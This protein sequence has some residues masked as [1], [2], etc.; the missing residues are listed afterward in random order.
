MEAAHDYL[1]DGKNPNGMTDKQLKDQLRTPDGNKYSQWV[2][3]IGDL[4]SVRNRIASDRNM[5][6]Q[7]KLDMLSE[8]DAPTAEAVKGLMEY[9]TNPVSLGKM[10]SPMTRLAQQISNGGYN[11]GYYHTAQKYRDPNTREGQV[12]DRTATLPVAIETV[13]DGL[14]EHSETQKIP[15]KVVEQFKNEYYEGDP[16]YSKVYSGIRMFAT[17]AIGIASGGKPPVTSVNDLIRHMYSTS[18]PAQIRSQMQTD[19]KTALAYIQNLNDRWRADTNNPDPNALAP[20][21]TR[22]SMN[23]LDAIM[24]MNPYTGQMPDDAPSSLRAVG[25]PKPTGKD[26]P[27]WMKEGQDYTPM[28]REDVDYWKGWLK[29]NSNDPR[30]QAIRE[31][32]RGIP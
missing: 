5:T 3:A 6:P 8:F 18:S 23:R 10:R 30:A 1:R 20:G 31:Q 13:L 11:E 2:S 27:S 14:K 25:K 26:R 19:A 29:D 17:D 4:N 32:L 9:R 21:V 12:V 7:Q 15:S 22:E 16:K 24:R 28:T